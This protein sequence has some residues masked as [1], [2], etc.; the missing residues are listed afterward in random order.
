MK[1]IDDADR[2]RLQIDDDGDQQKVSKHDDRL[3]IPCRVRS[4]IAWWRRVIIMDLLE[5]GIEHPGC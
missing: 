5:F 1:N 3:G 2:L 4:E